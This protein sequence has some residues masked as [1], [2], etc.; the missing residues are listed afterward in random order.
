MLR[1]VDYAKGKDIEWYEVIRQA[2]NES[3]VAPVVILTRG[4]LRVYELD[5]DEMIGDY[6]DAEPIPLALVESTLNPAFLAR[7]VH[8]RFPVIFKPVTKNMDGLADDFYQ[9][10]D[11]P[12]RPPAVSKYEGLER[13]WFGFSKQ[14]SMTLDD[15]WVPFDAGNVDFTSVA[16]VAKSSNTRQTTPHTQFIEHQMNQGEAKDKSWLFFKQLASHST[17]T[18]QIELPG[19]GPIFLKGERKDVESTIRY[20]LK[21]FEHPDDG[22]TVN[23]HAFNNDWDRI[24]TRK[25]HKTSTPPEYSPESVAGT[26]TPEYNFIENFE[27]IIVQGKQKPHTAFVEVAI[28]RMKIE[29]GK[30]WKAMLYIAQRSRGQT[31]VTL[32][33]CGKIYLKRVRLNPENEILYSHEQFDYDKAENLPNGVDLIKKTAFDKAWTQMA[34]EPNMNQT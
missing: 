28:T 27:D 1:I 3:S 12:I 10:D 11:L 14:V 26:P 7:L 25:F 20:S 17:G 5:E 23:K 31:E 16:K 30:A 13:V 4:E 15:L 18:E 19:Y 22:K 29:R 9:L 34:R 2:I 24:K 32:P 33:G 6:P 8:A 21:N